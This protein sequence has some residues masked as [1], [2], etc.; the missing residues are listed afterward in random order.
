MSSRLGHKLPK[1]TDAKIFEQM[2]RDC[3][4][5]KYNKKFNLYARTGQKQHGIDIYC[6]DRFAEVIQC[7]NY[8]TNDKK[9]LQGAINEDFQS[10]CEYFYKENNW[11]FTSFIVATSADKDKIGDDVIIEHNLNNDIKIDIWFWEDIEAI[12]LENPDLLLKYYKPFVIDIRELKIVH[13]DNATFAKSF[14]E[15]LFLHKEQP[16]SKVKLCNLFVMPK[17]KENEYDVPKIDLEDKLFAFVKSDKRFLFIEGDAGCGKS[18]LVS[19]MNYNENK[20]DDDESKVN[21]FNKRPVITIR[22]R[23][24][25]KEVISKKGLM[26]AILKYMNLDDKKDLHKRFPNAVMIL[27]GFDELCM[28]E[29]ILNHNSL[30]YDFCADEIRT[31]HYII[32]SRPQYIEKGINIPSYRIT[33]QHFDKDN[34][35]KWIEHYTS[36]DCCGQ[37]LNDETKDYIINISDDTDS[38]I[39]DT[40][41]TLYMLAAKNISKELTKNSWKLYNHIFYRALSETE[42]NQMI[43]E[44]Y[45][46]Y[47]NPI[48]QH[49][50][51]L[52]R[53]SEEIAYKMYQTN[54][55][56]LYV[57]SDEIKKIITYLSSK[58][59]KLRDNN[60][61]QR[62]IEQ[63]YALCNYWKETGDGAVEFYHNIIRD[64]FLCE[65]IYREL[66]AIYSQ[67]DLSKDN[68]QPLIDFFK[69]FTKAPLQD[70]VCKFI[71]LRAEKDVNDK[72]SFVYKEKEQRLLPYLFEEMLTNGELYDNLHEKKHIE[73]IV[74]ILS[75]TAQVYRHIYEYI[76]AEK[77]H[78][79][80][81]DN[82]ENIND[83][84]DVVK[85]LFKD[86]FNH[87][88][89][90]GDE[91]YISNRID[92][93]WFRL[94]EINLRN[95][96]F[97]CA[98][99]IGANLSSANLSSANLSSG[100]LSRA[101]L[102]CADL[103]HADL[104]HANLSIADLSRANLSIADLSRATLSLAYLSD[105]NLSDANLSDATLIY[106]N[107]SHADLSGANL[108]I[109]YLSGA[110]LRGA[111][112]SVAD[113]RG[114]TL[115]D[116]F[117][118]D[119]QEEQVQHLKDMNIEELEI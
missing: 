83:N 28:I 52:Y 65:K 55:N 30:I 39:C 27:D 41:M 112:L 98:D 102:S 42:Y 19:W 110:T 97:Q 23:S 95:M 109:A 71:F 21:I 62:M 6:V 31:Y 117:E 114:A 63:C 33:L 70:M 17:Y 93:H 45:E 2:V 116:G 87:K 89:M 78:M 85:C 113:L 100:Y 56:R 60:A 24:L 59:S 82:V 92:I 14:S 115:P 107:L 12:I 9:A 48:Y 26:S 106:A 53:I 36:P 86:I 88:L 44:E 54:N 1:K 50:D 99:L 101:D 8:T 76:L 15:T 22:L 32:T 20:S 38:A 66:N 84:S 18:T 4:N 40:P 3:A 90:S 13:T 118:S 34:R 119:S 57:V 111:D 91:Q 73:A 49:S 72:N 81:W 37:T 11:H 47:K 74:N 77:E 94:P 5:K 7:K 69:Q 104:S 16:D 29:G 58:E 96:D 43:V 105:A 75:C 10:A 68:L 25:D 64:F 80:W 108:S 103:S 61:L 79:K 51:I 67:R 35:E 46:S